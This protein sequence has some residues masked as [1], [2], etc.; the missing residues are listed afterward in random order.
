MIVMQNVLGQALG[1][2][3]VDKAVQASKDADR[4]AREQAAAARKRAAELKALRDAQRKEIEAQRREIREVE[5]GKSAWFTYVDSCGRP[6][7]RLRPSN[8]PIQPGIAL[9][10]ST[11]HK[12][13][14]AALDSVS[15]AWI[16]K[17]RAYYDRPARKKPKL[18]RVERAEDGGMPWSLRFSA[19]E[20]LHGDGQA[21]TRQWRKAIAFS[22]RESAEAFRKS[23]GQSALYLTPARLPEP[24]SA[25]SAQPAVVEAPHETDEALEN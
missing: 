13:A 10:S 8:H 23:L 14:T 7:A 12:S 16:E 17:I 15:P 22:T 11:R 24:K 19:R 21:A 20:Y 5:S 25:S 6:V 1:R 4:R 3:S 18:I 9:H 2:D